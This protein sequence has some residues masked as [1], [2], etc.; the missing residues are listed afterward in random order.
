[1][2]ISTEKTVTQRI[3]KSIELKYP[4]IENLIHAA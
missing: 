3:G 1:M 4:N 2:Y